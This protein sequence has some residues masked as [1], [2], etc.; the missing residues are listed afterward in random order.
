MTIRQ[1]KVSDSPRKQVNRG[2]EVPDRRPVAEIR[3][4]L[5]RSSSV[6]HLAEPDFNQLQ[7]IGNII[8]VYI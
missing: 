4:E 5:A 6:Y 7:T 1:R 8:S 3:A 2:V